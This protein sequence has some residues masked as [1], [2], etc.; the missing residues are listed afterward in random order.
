MIR[1]NN[2]ILSSL[3]AD[4]VFGDLFAPINKIKHQVFGPAANIIENE[5]EIQ[6]HLVIPGVSKENIKVEIENKTLNIFF[7]KSNQSLIDNEFYLRREFELCSFS[8]SFL[9][10]E[11]IDQNSITSKLE[12][13][14]L[15]INLPK[16]KGTNSKSKTVDI[17]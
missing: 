5:N 15:L 17:Q 11:N 9:I 16:I 1:K 2:P 10:S 4:D 3:M 12:N 6:I 14:I 8:R 7:E 13:G